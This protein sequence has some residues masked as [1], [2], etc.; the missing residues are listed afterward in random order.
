LADYTED[1]PVQL[2]L[3]G[4][5]PDV[6]PAGVKRRRPALIPPD[7]VEQVVIDSLQTIADAQDERIEWINMREQRYAKLRG[8]LE[9]RTW[10]WAEASNQ[11][12][13][14]MLANKLRMDAGLYNA[15]LGMR[16]LMKSVPTRVD[17][18]AVA[19]RIDHLLDHQM[20]VDNA[21]EK[22]IE[23]YIDQYTGDG[24]VFSYQPWVKERGTVCDTRT[25]PA[26]DVTPALLD[27]LVQEQIGQFEELVEHGDKWTGTYR[28]NDGIKRS[29][30]IT[31]YDSFD[32]GMMDITFEWDAPF[33]DGPTMIVLDLE[34]VVAP[35]RSE[36][37]Q[38]V[39]LQ[40]PNGAPWVATLH[41][42]DYDAIK[43]SKAHGIFDLLTDE[44]IEEMLPHAQ[45][46]AE[47][48]RTNDEEKLR[49]QRDELTGLAPGQYDEGRRWFT[50]VKYY[51]RRDVNGDGLDEDIIMWILKEPK[52]LARVKY[53]TE[54]YPGLPPRRPLSEARMIPVPGQ[55]YG[56]GLPEL[57][58]GLHEMIH[59]LVNQNI[60]SGWLS[61]IPFFG[62]RASSGFKPDVTELSPGLGIPL[63]NPQTD[64]IFPTMP[65]K[66]Q[67]W[68]FNMIGLGMQFLERLV[69]ISPIQF[70]QVPQGKASA[71]RT[72]GTT[73]ALL[74]QGSAMP[75]QILR[76]L[77]RGLQEVFGQFHQMNTRFLSKKK[78][79]LVT[80]R[81]LDS[82]EAYGLIEDRR[83]ISIPI[84]FSFEAT[85]L[86]TNKG[87]V[88]ESLAA[89]GS[90]M[91]SPLAIQFGLVDQEKMYNWA[92]DYIKSAQLDPSRYIKR[93]PGV[94][95]KPKIT[96][97]EA[98]LTILEG[99]LPVDCTPLEPPDEHLRKLMEYAQSDQ[100][101]FMTGGKELLFKQY[102]MYVQQ[103]VQQ[104]LQ[105]QQIMQAAQQ[106]SQMMGQGG[107]K[108]PGAPTQNA[109]DTSMQTEM[110]TSSELAGAEK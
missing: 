34:N 57:M 8:W 22:E 47:G 17:H 4:V 55:L 67:T 73:M 76:R 20:F 105:Q 48:D 37:L 44:E 95:D 83:D 19:E 12:I 88:A 107:G 50:L 5:E 41:R 90:A 70:G 30:T 80:G 1:A 108:G 91:F 72:T 94:S 32:D 27:A 92:Q 63:D 25:I 85:L 75:E 3:S 14:I 36:N 69:Q 11:H 38:P 18:R 61:N 54:L 65:T 60:D 81:P 28:D 109:P 58:E 42:I 62:Y 79:F 102:L 52:K 97:E 64:L 106:F 104:M 103:L 6:K 26:E 29:V 71:L 35:M 10:P 24:T 101:G 21:G 45:D 68:S 31:A 53:L 98:I 56:I 87:L 16:P 82:Q 74:Q 40:N 7:E 39:T 66:D 77:F 9:S 33:F 84:S 99:G 100:F 86:N 59:E 46:R 43:R 51:C 110:G 49:T 96:A 89:I 78:R 23:K 13:P 15:V 2:D 93:P